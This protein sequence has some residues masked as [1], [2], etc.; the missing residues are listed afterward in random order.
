M[1]PYEIRQFRD[2]TID[3]NSY[4]ARPVSLLTPEMRRF[5]RRA[6]SLKTILLV[7]ATVAALVFTA[8]KSTHRTAC[9]ICAPT[10]TAVAATLDR[11]A[12]ATAQ[13]DGGRHEV[14]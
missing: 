2:G 13:P 1:Q 5:C 6:A 11:A 10:N 8:S 7:T 4:F 12:G 3:Y 9:T 14:S